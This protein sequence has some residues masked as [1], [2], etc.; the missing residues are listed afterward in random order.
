MKLTISRSK[1]STSF[2]VHESY[3]NEKGHSTTRVVEKL[4]TA[5]FIKSYISHLNIVNFVPQ[6]L[7]I[8]Y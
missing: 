7:S 1:N 2:Y 5:E 4:G 6:Y 3:R 8:K